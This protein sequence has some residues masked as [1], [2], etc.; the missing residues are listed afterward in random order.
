[1]TAAAVI[2]DQARALGVSLRVE[3]GTIKAKGPPPAVE[4]ILPALREHKPALLKALTPAHSNDPAETC[5]HWLVIESPKKSERWF[6]PP[7][8]RAELAERYPHAVFAAIPEHPKSRTSGTH[9]DEI[10][11]MLAIVA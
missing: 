3:G 5:D 6:S 10:R 8:T 11:R 7:I 1:M 9:A 4:Q 2:L